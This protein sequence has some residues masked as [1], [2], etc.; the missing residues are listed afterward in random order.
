[1]LERDLRL[2]ALTGAPLPRGLDHLRRVA[3]GAA[4][5]PR[6]M[7]CTVTAAASINHL[8]L[9]EIDVGPYRTFFKL[10]PPLRAEDDRAALVAG[11]RATA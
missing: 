8:T 3:R 6:T 4:R 2:V 11:A 1:M 7:A 9:N 10:A 5:A